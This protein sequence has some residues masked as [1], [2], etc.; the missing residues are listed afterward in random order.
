MLNLHHLHYFWAVAHEGHLT[1]AAERLN[2]SQSAVSVQIARLEEGLGHALFERKGRRLELTEAGRIA[3]EHADAIFAT[4][5]DLEST[6]QH[7]GRERQALRVGAVST[8][9]RN[10]L[11]RF[12]EPLTRRDDV[13]LVVRSG[14]PPDLLRSLAAHQ[15]DVV[16]ANAA[17]PRDASAP[18]VVHTIAKQPVSLVGRPSRRRPRRLEDILAREPLVLPSAESSLRAGFEALVERLGVTPR[19]VAEVDDMA[20]L[21]LLARAHLGL[22]VVP[23]IV[24]RDEIASGRLAEVARL[25]GLSEIFYAVTRSRRFPNPLLRTLLAGLRPG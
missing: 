16:L 10:F 13:Q 20:M 24:V 19:V 8:L 4:A 5:R 3:L 9:S 2:V 15:I 17:P 14:A 1:R 11:L 12:I 25:P 23:T 6:L 21:R 18:W 7:T 22:A